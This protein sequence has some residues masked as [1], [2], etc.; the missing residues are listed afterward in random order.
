MLSRCPESKIDHRALI[1]KMD[2]QCCSQLNRSLRKEIANLNYDGCKELLLTECKLSKES[3]CKR[4]SPI[5]IFICHENAR[6]NSL[7]M[8]LGI[9]TRKILAVSDIEI[10][11]ENCLNSCDRRIKQD[12]FP[13]Y[14]SFEPSISSIIEKI[15]VENV[16]EKIITLLVEY[17]FDI[18]E[19]D[20]KGWTAL[21]HSIK[22]GLSNITRALINARASSEIEAQVSSWISKELPS[23]YHSLYWLDIDTT[24]LLIECNRKLPTLPV[25]SYTDAVFLPLNLPIEIRKCLLSI[26]DQ[27]PMIFLLFVFVIKTYGDPSLTSQQ[28]EDLLAK[29]AEFGKLFQ[30]INC[31]YSA[32]PQPLINF[33]NDSEKSLGLNG[34]CRGRFFYKVVKALFKMD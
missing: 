23:I 27:S 8:R 25:H 20:V 12:S 18:N 29:A 9:E 5:F 2:S 28:I 3:A 31:F 13:G 30:E 22:Y 14:S 21:H 11:I 1:T 4:H 19:K 6:W 24:R 26:H 34:Y 33:L 17:D 7:F 16:F 32:P 10:E 15:F